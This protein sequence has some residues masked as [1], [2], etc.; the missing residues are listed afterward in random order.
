[1]KILKRNVLSQVSQQMLLP[2]LTKALLPLW[3]KKWINS[4]DNMY[5]DIWNKNSVK[6][7]AVSSGTALKWDC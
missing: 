6:Q 5:K 4:W 3:H 1:M 2:Y 7:Q